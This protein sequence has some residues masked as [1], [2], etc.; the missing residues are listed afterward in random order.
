M[1][2]VM[3][4]LPWLG[5]IMTVEAVNWLEVIF[6]LLFFYSAG[7]N[8]LVSLLTILPLITEIV[9]SQQTFCFSS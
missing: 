2:K 7:F 8:I 1:V 5:L 9:N 3:V 6:H 4:V